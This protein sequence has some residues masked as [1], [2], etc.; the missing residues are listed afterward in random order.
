MTSLFLHQVIAWG[1]VAEIIKARDQMGD[2][3][4]TVEAVEETTEEII[5]VNHPITTS[6]ADKIRLEYN[7][8]S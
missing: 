2:V 5:K 8:L 3:E 1:T 4:E 7:L 6:T